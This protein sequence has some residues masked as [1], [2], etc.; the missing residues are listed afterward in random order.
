MKK[1]DRRARTHASWIAF[2]L[3][4]ISGVLLTV[5]LPF[6]FWTL[7]LALEN[8]AALDAALK[9]YEAP[10]FKFGEW[11]L[12]FFLALHALGGI[13]ILLIEFRPWKG[14]RLGWISASFGTAAIVSFVFLITIL[15]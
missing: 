3:H 2:C 15:S 13:R 4:R 11:L 10:I 8:E 9:W 14:L 7:G 1:N 5:F 6:H 12:V